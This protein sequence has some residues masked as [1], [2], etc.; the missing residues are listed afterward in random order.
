[1]QNPVFEMMGTEMSGITQEK[2]LYHRQFNENFVSV[3]T[4]T[5]DQYSH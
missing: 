1:M 4:K 5:A 3:P 2:N